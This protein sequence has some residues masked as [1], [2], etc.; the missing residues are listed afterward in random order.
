MSSISV[1]YSRWHYKSLFDNIIIFMYSSDIRFVTRGFRQ[2][3][4]LQ[5][6]VEMSEKMHF[7][8]SDIL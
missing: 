3:K 5:V 8:L 1:K 2:H 7:I 4:C 6:I